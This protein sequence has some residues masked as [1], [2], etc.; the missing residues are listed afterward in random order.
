MLIAITTTTTTTTTTTATAMGIS[1]AAIYGA[2]GVVILILL[3]IAKEL[4]SSYVDETEGL[5]DTEGGGMVMNTKAKSLAENL[6]TAIYPLLFCFALIV[7]MKVF[8]VL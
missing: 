1:Q 2:F 8:E 5:E 6:S 3:L 7:V 4:L